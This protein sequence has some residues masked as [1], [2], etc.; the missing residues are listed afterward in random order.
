MLGLIILPFYVLTN[1]YLYK[2]LIGWLNIFINFS[3]N[4]IFKIILFI[5]QMLLV[6][7]PYIA[8]IMPSNMVRKI[9]FLL[10][11]Y[12]LG[13]FIYALIILLISFIFKLIIK[14][15]YNQRIHFYLG[16]F[17]VISL[18]SIMLVGNYSAKN[19]SV[20]RYTVDIEKKVDNLDTLNIVMVADLHLGYNIGLKHIQ[21][22]V[23][24]INNEK[25]DIVLIAGDIFDNE[26]AMIEN[27]KKMINILKSIK[28][29]YG[30]YAVYGNHD[31]KERT[32]IGFTFDGKNKK[33]SD[34]KMDKFLDKAN[35]KLLKDDYIMIDDNIYVY[36]RLDYSNYKN[37]TIRKKANKITNSLDKSKPIIILDHQPKE[38]DSLASSGVDL[39]LSGHTHDGQIFPINYFIKLFY[40]NS[41][42]IK[43]YNNMT[44]IVTSGVGLYGPN[45]RVLT[46]AEITSIKV[47]FK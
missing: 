9:L 27:P 46:K 29:K 44:S 5:I 30:T 4:K 19:I 42:G 37:K 1:I 35:I 33:T 25:P 15:Y 32:L 12:Y 38:L 24:K 36:G 7:F 23:N 26:Y 18:I 14:K 28:S 10:G 2:V 47:N 16:L 17:V 20:T 8:Y 11:N 40:K 45:M 22:M 3:K 41:Y 31:V 13:L 21:R 34:I 43:K 6:V 39:D